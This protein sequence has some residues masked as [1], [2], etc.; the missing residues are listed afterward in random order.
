VRRP[1]LPLLRSP[2]AF[3]EQAE[4]ARL[5]Y[6]ALRAWRAPKGL[7]AS[8]RGF[9]PISTNLIKAWARRMYFVPEGRHDRSLAQKCLESATPKM[10]RPVGYGLIL[11][12]VRSDSM[13]GVKKLAK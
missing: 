2:A 3:Q 5:T 6:Q 9:N 7:N 4:T 11:A 12:G 10:S 1:A 8:A 13:I